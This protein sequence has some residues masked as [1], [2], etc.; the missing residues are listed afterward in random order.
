MQD[1]GGQAIAQQGDVSLEDDVLSLLWTALHE[2]GRLDLWV[3]NAGVE[4]YQPT[5]RMSLNE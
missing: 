2:F 3:N 1:Q 5:E 4:N